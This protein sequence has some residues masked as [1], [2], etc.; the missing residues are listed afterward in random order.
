MT[1]QSTVVIGY[2][3]QDMTKLG[4]PCPCADPGDYVAIEVTGL[5]VLIR[6][7]CGR[8]KAGQLDDEA[9]REV[10]IKEHSPRA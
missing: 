1:D 4:G 6:C 10:F 9:E 8:T 3:H 2:R 7:W 5:G